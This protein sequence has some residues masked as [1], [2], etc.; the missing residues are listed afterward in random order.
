MTTRVQANLWW[1][2]LF[3]TKQNKFQSKVNFRLVITTQQCTLT[4]WAPVLDRTVTSKPSKIFCCWYFLRNV[5]IWGGEPPSL[6]TSKR[7]MEICSDYSAN[8][9]TTKPWE[10]ETWQSTLDPCMR[11]RPW[12]SWQAS[13]AYG[14]P[15]ETTGYPDH[16][17]R[18]MRQMNFENSQISA[19]KDNNLSKEAREG[20]TSEEETSSTRWRMPGMCGAELFS[21][22]AGDDENPRGGP[23]R[24]KKT[25][26]LTDPK[27]RQKCVNCYWGICITVWCFDQGKHYILWL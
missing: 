13:E 18:N 27:H 24:G 15:F 1:S 22:G 3:T 21:I 5:K 11:K 16:N 9:V 26:K 10:R 4:K 6:H 14:K 23:G 25:R 8:S 20:K 12:N 7:S 19:F 2:K 17:I